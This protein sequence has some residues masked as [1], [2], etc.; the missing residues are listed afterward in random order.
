VR[1][2]QTSSLSPHSPG[3]CLL[4]HVRF[5]AAFIRQSCWVCKL[6]R[7]Y[8]TPGTLAQATGDPVHHRE[9]SDLAALSSRYQHNGSAGCSNGVP[10]AAGA[11]CMRRAHKQPW[12]GESGHPA[13]I[14]ATS[15]GT[16]MLQTRL[17]IPIYHTCPVC[18]TSVARRRE[19]QSLIAALQVI[20]PISRNYMAFLYD[21]MEIRSWSPSECNGGGEFGLLAPEQTLEAHFLSILAEQLTEPAAAAAAVVARSQPSSSTHN[22]WNSAGQ[23]GCMASLH[24]GGAPCLMVLCCAPVTIL[25]RAFR[26]QQGST[27]L[28]FIQQHNPCHMVFTAI[29]H[30]TASQ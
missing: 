13:T 23:I 18:L 15:G 16:H 30:A 4:Q 3:S 8:I 27:L 29:C 11:A 26:G 28:L 7:R 1:A 14:P 5:T 22:S 10:G 2:G 12:L 17:V 21:P 6:L 9:R 24:A 20:K 19:H 25:Y